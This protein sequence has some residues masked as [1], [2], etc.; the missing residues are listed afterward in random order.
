L[1]YAVIGLIAFRILS[2]RRKLKGAGGMAAIDKGRSGITIIVESAALY[3]ATVLSLLLTYV[4]G[5]NAQ[6]VVLD[7][8]S[9]AL[10]HPS[11]AI[12]QPHICF[13]RNFFG[14]VI[15]PVFVKLIFMDV[16][17]QTSPIIGI[18]FTIIIL[19]VSLGLSSGD[20]PSPNRALP[21]NA[22]SDATR[23]ITTIGGSRSYDAFHM[24][25][26]GRR[27][28]QA[29]MAVN[30]TQFRVVEVDEDGASVDTRKGAD[31]VEAGIESPSKE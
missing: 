18:T 27:A 28:N 3:S 10:L 29:P 4:S 20:S 7:M 11:G 13:P 30:V 2:T 1:T 26:M 31:D 19:R 22:S 8:V 21:N 16:A 24:N 15:L 23:H 6:Y 12:P 25:Q 17:W 5:S 14:S 9:A